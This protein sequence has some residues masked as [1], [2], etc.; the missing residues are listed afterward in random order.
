MTRRTINRIC[1]YGAL[2]LTMLILPALCHPG[3]WDCYQWGPSTTCTI[4][5]PLD[6]EKLNAG[7]DKFD[8]NIEAIAYRQMETII[9]FA[10]DPGDEFEDFLSWAAQQGQ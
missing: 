7:R 4:H 8:A 9:T 5:K 3:D 10:P 2:G 6:Y 1:F